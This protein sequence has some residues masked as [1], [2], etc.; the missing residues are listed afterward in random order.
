MRKSYTHIPS[1]VKTADLVLNVA[2]QLQFFPAII[3]GFMVIFWV[4]LPKETQ[5]F[6]SCDQ[7]MQQTSWLLS[8]SNLNSYSYAELSKPN[9]PAW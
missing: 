3:S 2:C 4:I 7:A 8:L 6:Y 5:K 1:N 9:C